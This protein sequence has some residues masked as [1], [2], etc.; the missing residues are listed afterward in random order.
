[1]K[2]RAGLLSDNL[3]TKWW[4]R[5]IA[6]FFFLFIL[7][8][9]EMF[10]ASRRCLEKYVTLSTFTTAGKPGTQEWGK[11]ELSDVVLTQSCRFCENS[12]FKL[13]KRSENSLEVPTIHVFL[14]RT[15]WAGVDYPR[16]TLGGVP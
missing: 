14:Q 4:R 16:R 6:D 12:V 11:N 5:L 10:M 3:L 13:L 1:M 15:C 9:A 8:S 2:K 7:L